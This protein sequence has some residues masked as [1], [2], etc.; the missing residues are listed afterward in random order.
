[1]NNLIENKIEELVNSTLIEIEI[2]STLEPLNKKEI[3]D[4]LLDLGNAY[5]F[6]SNIQR[7]INDLTNKL[8]DSNEL[9]D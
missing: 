8:N 5:P 6:S 2:I 7:R 9:Y 4:M 1:M 3:L